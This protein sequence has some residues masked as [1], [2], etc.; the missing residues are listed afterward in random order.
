MMPGEYRVPHS[1]VVSA[2]ETVPIGTD[3]VITII[4]DGSSSSHFKATVRF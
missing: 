4:S 3:I 2:Q 1:R